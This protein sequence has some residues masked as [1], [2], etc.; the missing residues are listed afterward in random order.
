MNTT[1]QNIELF[2][3]IFGYREEEFPFPLRVLLDIS[4]PLLFEL[5]HQGETYLLYVLRDTTKIIDG[6]HITVQELVCS[7]VKHDIISK[8]TKSEISIHDAFFSADTVWRTGK[9]GDK[10]FPPK[11]VENSKDIEDRFPKQNVKLNE[12][13][14]K[15]RY[16]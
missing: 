15:V 10:V 12:L 14:N 11:Q 7:K 4:Q 1:L 5:Q 13:P 6:T 8:L 9:I 3:A 16:I 2:N